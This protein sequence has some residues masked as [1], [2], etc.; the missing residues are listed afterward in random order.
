MSSD[1]HTMKKQH[2]C[3]I[4]LLLALFLFAVAGTALAAT[5]GEIKVQADSAYAARKYEQARD[6]YLQLTKQGQSLGIYYNLACTYYRL[7]DYPNSVLWF[8]RAA[9]LDPSD[10]DVKHNLAMARGKTIDRITPVHSMFFVSAWHSLTRYMS[11]TGWAYTAIYLFVFTLLMT[12]IYLW[13]QNIILRKIGFF[14]AIIG[15][16]LCLLSNICA[17]SQRHYN[18]N[19]SAGILMQPAVTVKSTPEKTGND[20]FVIH[21]G[22]RVEIKDDSMKDWVE[23]SIADG[24]SGWIQRNTFQEI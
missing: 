10:E 20:L 3:N 9:K 7:E 24:K 8:E 19:H 5:P 18:Q 13:S 14:S 22:T 23:I 11:V 1:T 6:L 2:T 21:Q 12:G 15:I 4:I 16:L 17:Y